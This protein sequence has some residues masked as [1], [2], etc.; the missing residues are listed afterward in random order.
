METKDKSLAVY[1]LVKARRDAANRD[2]VQRMADLAARREAKRLFDEDPDNAFATKF[3]HPHS[4]TFHEQAA[5]RAKTE[6]DN[7]S[8][9]L[10]HVVETF[11]NG[12]KP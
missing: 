6:V 10:D 8:E 9:V 4:T 3:G 1:R 11:L 7:W 5:D 12:E 2:Y